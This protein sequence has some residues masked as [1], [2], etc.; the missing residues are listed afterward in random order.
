LPGGKV[1][2]TRAFAERVRIA[3]EAS[4]ADPSIPQVTVSAGVTAG[5]APEQMDVLLMRADTAMYAANLGG[6]NRTAVCD[7]GS[8]PRLRASASSR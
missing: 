5:V 8:E 1:D 6:R 7:E 2:D 4:A 3:F